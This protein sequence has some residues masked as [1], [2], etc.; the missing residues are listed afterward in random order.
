MQDSQLF[1]IHIEKTSGS[2]LVENL[3]RPN[4]PSVVSLGGIT[5]YIANR[6]A[7]CVEGHNP[8]G[9]HVFCDKRVDYIT[10][11]RDPVERA[12]SFYYYVRD[13]KRTDL[14]KRHPLRDYADSVTII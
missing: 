4:V 3:L 10:M 7:E 14:V 8:Y 5:N 2:S 12:I 13:L 11:L 6:N 1:F 9:Y